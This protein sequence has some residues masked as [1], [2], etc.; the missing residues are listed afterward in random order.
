MLV[1]IAMVT[2]SLSFLAAGIMNNNDNIQNNGDATLGLTFGGGTGTEGD[3]YLISSLDYLCSL[4][5]AVYA[6]NSMSGVYFK[7]TGDISI[8]AIPSPSPASPDAAAGTIVYAGSFLPIGFDARP[9]RGVFDGNGFSITNL[10]DLGYITNVSSDITFMGLFGYVGAEGAVMNL[11]IDASCAVTLTLVGSGS[12]NIKAGALIGANKG[13][14]DN[15]INNGSVSVN[16]SYDGPSNSDKRESNVGGIAGFN[17]STGFIE[18]SQNFGAISLTFDGGAGT[19]TVAQAGGIVG[20]NSNGATVFACNNSGTVNSVANASSTEDS[21]V[22]NRAGGV[23]G[24][25]F[26][27]TIYDSD[28]SGIVSASTAVASTTGGQQR[29]EVFAGGIAGHNA[30]IDLSLGTIKNCYNTGAVDGAATQSGELNSTCAL[31]VGGI[32]GQSAGIVEDCYNTGDITASASNS[33]YG[34]GAGG[35]VGVMYNDNSL[36]QNCY[37]TGNIRAGSGGDNLLWFYGV[38]GIVGEIFGSGTLAN[39]YNLGDVSMD[40]ALTAGDIGGVIGTN[41]GGTVAD[42]YW[43]QFAVQ[44]VNGTP[45]TGVGIGSGEGTAIMFNSD[46]MLDGAP[47]TVW[48]VEVSTLLDALNAFVDSNP[49]LNAWQ[50]ISTANSGFPI[51]VTDYH[52]LSLSTADNGRIYWSLDGESFAILAQPVSFLSG[53]TVY[54]KGVADEGFEFGSWTGAVSGTENPTTVVMNDDIEVGATFDVPLVLSPASILV[55]VVIA[56]AMI[57]LLCLVLFG[58]RKK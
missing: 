45:Q 30:N 42:C 41:Y 21:A 37:N 44:N 50:E 40:F 39:C 28:N 18:N 25:N 9:F 17:E 52:T 2:V 14:V 1:A 35:V 23:A 12:E 48:D 15:C 33:V 57:A 22:H 43:Y 51:F 29:A 24:F 8:P 6:G 54:L 26:G 58:H 55:I 36:T 27:G 32:S 11:T 56:L 53:T 47:I 13:T 4:S 3:P 7:M 46:H 34:I 19:L 49:G 31:E 10:T 16:R 38:G 20:W 5:S